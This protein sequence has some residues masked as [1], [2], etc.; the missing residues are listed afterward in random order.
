M[1]K[2]VLVGPGASLKAEGLLVQTQQAGR[3][4]A[5]LIEPAAGVFR[6]LLESQCRWLELCSEFKHENNHPDVFCQVLSQLDGS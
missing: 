3:C 1:D 4:S 2:R 5:G 6:G